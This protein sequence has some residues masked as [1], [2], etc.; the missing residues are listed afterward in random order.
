MHAAEA[1]LAYEDGAGPWHTSHMETRADFRGSIKALQTAEKDGTVIRR[2][3]MLVFVAQR[4]RSCKPMNP[5]NTALGWYD[6]TE[7]GQG[8]NDT[9]RDLLPRHTCTNTGQKLKCS[10][11]VADVTVIRVSEAA[12]PPRQRTQSTLSRPLSPTTM[13]SETPEENTVA[14]G[15]HTIDQVP[16]AAEAAQVATDH[17]L[18]SGEVSSSSTQSGSDSSPLVTPTSP[19]SFR[20]LSSARRTVYVDVPP[21]SKKRKTSANSAP[22]RH[23]SP[24]KSTSAH[25][26]IWFTHNPTLYLI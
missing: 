17:D 22:S 20:K 24:T 26:V 21:R 10:R 23:I 25:M 9:V 16:I 11:A 8:G 13:S 3:D 7:E 12:A 2:K 18:S 15:E 14:V 5:H 19:T 4:Y 6:K 1:M